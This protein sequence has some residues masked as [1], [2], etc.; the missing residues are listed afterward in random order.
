MSYVKQNF[1]G[2][3]VLTAT[4]LNHME[5]GIASAGTVK[6]VNGV[7]PNENGNIEFG[8]L[9]KTVTSADAEQDGTV[10]SNPTRCFNIV[11]GSNF[12]IPLNTY[13]QYTA[14]DV[15]KTFKQGFIDF[16]FSRSLMLKDGGMIDYYC[17]K[18]E[19]INKD[20]WAYHFGD[21][22]APIIV[23]SINNTFELDPDWV[24]P[25]EPEK[26][27]MFRS[28]KGTTTVEAFGTEWLWGMADGSYSGNDLHME[29]VVIDNDKGIV[30]NYDKTGYEITSLV[31]DNN[32]NPIQYIVKFYFGDNTC[33]VIA[34]L[35]K[36][37][38][39]LDPD[40][41]APA[42]NDP[43]CKILFNDFTKYG[44][45]L[46]C[47]KSMEELAD[48]LE[49]P[50]KTGV[51]CELQIADSRTNISQIYQHTEIEW[52]RNENQGKIYIIKF[53]DKHA[54]VIFDSDALTLSLDSDWVAPAIM[55]ETTEAHKQL[56]TDAEGKM[57]WEDKLA[58][59][60]DNLT[61][62][63]AETTMTAPSSSS[64]ITPLFAAEP[65]MECV[66]KFDGNIY[67]L[68]VESHD[69]FGAVLGNRT[70]IGEEGDSEIP[71]CF[72]TLHPGMM[73]GVYFKTN[74]IHTFSIEVNDKIYH[75]LDYK[76]LPF[77]ARK[78]VG[79][80]GVVLNN[81]FTQGNAEGEYS[82]A[83]NC[84]EA[85][86]HYS[87][88]INGSRTEGEYSF[89]SGYHSEAN[90]LSSMAS[91]YYTKASSEHQFASGKLNIEDK[92]NK[93]LH[94]VGNGDFENGSPQ[95]SNAHTLD[96]DGNAWYQ[97]DV[98]VGGTSQADGSKLITE[99]QVTEK[100][101]LPKLASGI[102]HGQ[103]GQFAVSD[104]MGGIMWKTLFEVEE[105]G[106]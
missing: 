92:E 68:M 104:G 66:V 41:T 19:K 55:P 24:V 5:D 98:Y 43:I 78:G 39:T 97:G 7:I 87:F 48:A 76:Y 75:P 64:R 50:V 35:L 21:N 17:T 22:L 100:V 46:Q 9:L 53:G 73:S 63:V 85:A 37:E 3:Q 90:G 105:V 23:D 12:G 86:A 51:V 15:N 57:A 83:A 54:P 1:S 47:N 103:A 20:K 28:I 93:Y 38:I 33:P 49:A 77:A 30:I 36:Q 67:N 2:G 25:S 91:G 70:L 82:V 56:V 106:Y 95:Y 96:W 62:L 74:A 34:D 58:Y 32:S 8:K 89:A 79:R 16:S 31:Y 26:Y 52:Y 29:H 71:F 99:E 42:A 88:A 10:I 94:I 11:D 101:S 40:W 4:N 60:V 27:V 59:R 84:G 13:N 69:A 44:L 14:E 6:S 81:F 61:T 102:D 65:G 80:N 72:I 45:G 18:V